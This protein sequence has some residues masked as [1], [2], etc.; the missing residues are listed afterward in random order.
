MSPEQIEQ[1]AQE[2]F[3]QIAQIINN[4][5]AQAQARNNPETQELMRQYQNLTIENVRE[6]IVAENANQQNQQNQPAT[7]IKSLFLERPNS[8]ATI[9]FTPG[10]WPG[11]KECFAPF[12]KIAPQDCNLLFLELGGHGE[13]P[14][15]SCCSNASSCLGT[16]DYGCCLPGLPEW[17]TN[18]S[19]CKGANFFLGLKEY[20]LHEYN[21]IIAAISHTSQQLAQGKPIILFG[22]CA[23]AFISARTLIK[24]REMS[25]T[26]NDLI[27]N[28][29]IQGLIFDSGFAS[30]ADIM[31]NAKGYIKKTFLKGI[32]SSIA[33]FIVN[34]LVIAP[35]KL[36]FGPSI[37]ENNLEINLY[38]KIQTI[39]D[40]KTFFIH[41]TNDSLA[42]IEKIKTLSN[43]ITNKE[44]WETEGDHHAK[45][46]LVYKEQY[47]T[48][49]TDWLN[50]TI[51][52]TA[53]KT[54]SNNTTN[55]KK[56]LNKNIKRMIEITNT[57]INN[58][59]TNKQ[60]DEKIFSEFMTLLQD[61]ETNI[62]ANTQN[63]IT[64]KLSTLQNAKTPQEQIKTLEE[65]KN[66]LINIKPEDNIDKNCQQKDID[67]NNIPEKSELLTN[68]NNYGPNQNYQNPQQI[69]NNPN[70]AS[71]PEQK[72]HPSSYQNNNGQS[73]ASPS[74]SPSRSGKSNNSGPSGSQSPSRKNNYYGNGSNGGGYSDY[75]NPTTKEN[76][77][78]EQPNLTAGEY[79]MLDVNYDDEMN[80]IPDRIKWFARG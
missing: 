69:I 13:S 68:K 31:P 27:K 24:L 80:D 75:S 29:N 55:N 42:P 12:V 23:G 73:P 64:Q 14:S 35:A 17:L 40:I 52:Y 2:R 47:K 76:T 9:I 3:A 30:I 33:D 79:F 45:N 39:S 6:T 20:G 18:N 66:I 53:P 48:K 62:P 57:L 65:I 7:T 16:P 32:F 19:L 34:W 77:N 25:T 74:S 71:N 46:Q 56:E 54:Q 78:N 10:F 70:A 15:K 11:N 44:F 4:P 36:I 5:Q 61:K 43:N 38:D 28:F 50:N 26:E 49:L 21:E 72:T 58:I 1:V 67:K 51:Q 22:W 63:E 60:P 8:R 41:S 37:R 59:K